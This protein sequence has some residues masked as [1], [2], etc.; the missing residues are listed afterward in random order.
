VGADR[1]AAALVHAGLELSTAGLVAALFPATLYGEGLRR[2]LASL[3]GAGAQ[4]AVGWRGRLLVLPLLAAAPGLLLALLLI[5]PRAAR[6]LHRGGSVSLVAVIVS[7]LAVWIVLSPA[8][9]WVYRVVGPARPGWPATALGGS[10]TAANLS[11]F[12]HGFILFCSLP[13]DLGLPFGGFAPVGATVAVA[14]WLY[15]VHTV[16]LV[17]YALTVQLDRFGLLREAAPAPVRAV[18]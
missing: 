11:G 18:P 6:L 8:L 7:F 12:L 13:L 16:V 3:A 5:L 1:A 14:L 9:I 17:G 2:S 15:L 10:F 4:R